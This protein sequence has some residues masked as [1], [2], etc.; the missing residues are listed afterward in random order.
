MT[1]SKKTS[2]ADNTG[3]AIRENVVKHK[4]GFDLEGHVGEVEAAG[5]HRFRRSEAKDIPRRPLA[6]R[7]A[8]TTKGG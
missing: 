2:D 8:R 5:N 1:Q 6:E 7:I 4:P 3:F